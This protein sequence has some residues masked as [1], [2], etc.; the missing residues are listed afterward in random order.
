[1]TRALPS[2][3]LVPVAGDDRL[4]FERIYG[5]LFE[6][7][8][9]VVERAWDG[10]PFADAAALARCLAAVIERASADEQM[11]LIRA[12]PELGDRIGIADGTLTPSSAS[13]QASA[14]L[15]RLTPA[16]FETFRSLNDAYRAR[17]G[18][19]FII[20]VRLH[21]LAGIEAAMRRRLDNDAETER[22]EALRQ[23]ATIGTLRLASVVQPTGLPA[24]ERRLAH[25]LELLAFPQD[26]SERVHDEAGRPILDVAIVGGGQCGL[27]AAFGLRREGVRNILVLDENGQGTEG[28]WVTY[29]R[30]ITLRTPKELTPIDW[31][32]PA[33][34]FRAW[35]EAQYGEAA[36]A[37]LGR[38]P[39]EDWMRYLLWYR[40]VLD[41]PVRND[42]HVEL[43]EPLC[44]R[45]ISRAASASPRARWCW[46][47][48]SRAAVRGGRRISCA[49]ACP[50]ISTR[51]A[52]R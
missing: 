46:R 48:A 6:R 32:I 12:H 40:R 42:A 29:A 9:W 18:F 43:I 28:P 5:H 35:W 23:V 27:A 20:C 38:I 50:R 1:M 30:M 15:D 14:G 36:W 19:P 25:E 17:F 2:L 49:R 7:S 33:L 4:T 24:H 3:D 10:R 13:E 11:A 47:P 22:A 41:L 52:R 21:D 44:S 34:T 45:C 51:T 26:W 8:P 37:G 16:Q 39:R 31:G